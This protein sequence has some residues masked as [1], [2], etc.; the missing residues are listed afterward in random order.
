M[1]DTFRVD[2]IGIGVAKSGST[3]LAD[4]LRAHPQIFV[5]RIKEIQYFHKVRPYSNGLR[6]INYDRS[7]S[8]Y[9]NHFKKRLPDQLCGEISPDYFTAANV[10]VDIYAYNPDIKLILVFR[11]PVDQI[12]SHYHYLSQIGL[13][14]SPNFEEALSTYPD[15]LAECYYTKHLQRYLDCFD[16]KNIGIWLYD[17]LVEDREAFFL[18][19]L[20]F[21]G[22]SHVIPEIFNTKSN[23]AKKAH[24]PLFNFYLDQVRVFLHKKKLLGVIKFLRISGISGIVEWI[25]DKLNQKEILKKSPMNP[26]TR[27][28]LMELL[29]KDI[30]QLAKLIN[31]D[32]SNW[33]D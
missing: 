13:I 6:N 24:F 11:N 16:E 33:L 27:K 12:Y 21:L 14:H 25:R 2:F 9:H 26:A 28:K 8:W 32:L 20:N 29:E 3:W 19:V 31:R 30:I 4:C 22:V 10:A 15:L 1:T 5:S 18:S 7:L 17:D 23:V